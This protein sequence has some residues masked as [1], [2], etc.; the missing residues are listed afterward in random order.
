GVS[1]LLWLVVTPYALSRLGPE[2]FAVWSLFFVFGG[3]L[4]SLDL[5]MT[6]GVA[7]YT[8][9]AV[10]RGDHRSL[11]STLRRALLLRGLIGL[12]WFVVV[13]V[14]RGALVEAF[15]VPAPLRAEVSRSLIVF[16]FAMFAFAV[17]Q[18]LNGALN[19][20]QRLDLSN[21]CFLSGLTLHTL[22]LFLGL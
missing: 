21:A 11:I 18:V 7:R 1:A 19:G 8:A 16:G 12:A 5:G 22:V 20:F 14:G 2:R 4:A 15:H 6:N 13:I 10:A 17:T 3:Y 9:L